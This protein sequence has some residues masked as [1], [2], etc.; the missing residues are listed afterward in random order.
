M[1]RIFAAI[2]ISF[3]MM[4]LAGPQFGGI[5]LEPAWDEMQFLEILECPEGFV[6]TL[7][8]RGVAEGEMEKVFI[9][10]RIPHEGIPCPE[11]TW[12]YEDGDE[13]GCRNPLR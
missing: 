12:Y 5:D 11:G 6:N 3:P 13:I 1:K 4:A 9:C 8:A 10:E 7:D 2:V